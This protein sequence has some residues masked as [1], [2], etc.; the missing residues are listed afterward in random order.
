[1]DA[2]LSPLSPL[3]PAMP[4]LVLVVAIAMFFLLAWLF[5]WLWNTSVRKAFRADL[6]RHISYWDAVGL[7]V[8]VS[9]FVGGGSAV[10]G[11]CRRS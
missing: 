7:L 2:W 1:M 11:A 10:I 5:Q 9:L 6:T 4:V 3:G 8:F